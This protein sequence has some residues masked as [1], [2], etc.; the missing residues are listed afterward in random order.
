MPFFM[1]MTFYDSAPGRFNK[2]PYHISCSLYC[3]REYF[4]FLIIEVY[5]LTCNTKKSL[6]TDD[7]TFFTTNMLGISYA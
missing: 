3:R 2:K 5:I 1:I 6:K 4:D 7:I